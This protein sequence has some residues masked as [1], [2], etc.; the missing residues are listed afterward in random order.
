MQVKFNTFLHPNEHTERICLYPVTQLDAVL[1]KIRHFQISKSIF[2]AK[3]DLIFLK[4]KFLFEYQIRTIT[5]IKSIYFFNHSCK[6]L[7]SKNV[8]YFCQLR[9]KLSYKIQTNP[10]RMFIR[11]QKCIEFHLPPYEIPQPYSH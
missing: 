9:L 1:S 8:P 3:Y 11:V 2:K 10:F 5:F 6:T 7:F 4:P